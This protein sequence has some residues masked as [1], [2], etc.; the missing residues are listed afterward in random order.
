MGYLVIIGQ[1]FF[2]TFI[3]GLFVWGMKNAVSFYVFSRK[4]E[5]INQLHARISILKLHLKGKIKRKCNKIESLFKKSEDAETLGL[6]RPKLNSI[7]EL[8]FGSTTDYQ[9]L[10][11]TLTI[12]TQ[13]IANH[14][15][16]KHRNLIKKQETGPATENSEPLS[17]D[18]QI[19]EDCKKLVKYDK[20]HMLIVVEIIQATENL[21]Q[22]I[23]E[24]N[25]MTEYE[26][27]Q[28]KI[29][30]IPEKIEIKHYDI[31]AVFVEQSKTSNIDTPDFQILEK[32]SVDSAA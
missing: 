13:D 15:K 22:E 23:N 1:I 9:K 26:K 14:I 8:A 21:I 25:I 30:E 5:K 27:N 10:I 32:S 18:E 4:R 29:K 24:F 19:K 12:I 28:K 6:L 17:E 16:I 3:L 7:Q 11:D 31:I 20:A 2:Y